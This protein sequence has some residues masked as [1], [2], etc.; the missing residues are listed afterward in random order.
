VG[1]QPLTYSVPEA[2]AL[3]G[4]SSWAAYEA[5]KRGELP[6]RKIGRRIVVPKIQLDAWLSAK[7]AA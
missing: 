4:I 7:G 1:D 5:I 6:A 2:A 3:L